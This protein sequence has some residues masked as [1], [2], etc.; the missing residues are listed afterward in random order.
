MTY[1]APRTCTV[2]SEGEVTRDAKERTAPLSGYA[3]DGAYVLIAEPGAGKTTAF[4]TEAASQGGVYVTVRNFR[5]FDD[6]PE[7]HDTTLFLDG[8]DESR[9]GTE[10]GRTPLDDVRKKLNRLGCPPF[11]LSCRWADWMAASDKEALKDVSP[12]GTVTVIRLDPYQT[13]TSSPYSL[14]TMAWRTPTPLSRRRGPV[15]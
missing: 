11:R 10:D 1:V 9:V 15:G 5:T 2:V 7:W 4:E 14:T 13:R 12:D 3:K 6:K 8:L